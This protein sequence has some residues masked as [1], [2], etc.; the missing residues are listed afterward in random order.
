MFFKNLCIFVLWMKVVLALEGLRQ[1]THNS[2]V[3]ASLIDYN[4]STLAPVSTLLMH[5]LHEMLRLALTLPMLRLL[6][7]KEQGCK[8]FWIPSKPCHVGIHWIALTEYSQMS[9]HVPGFQ[10]FFRFFAT[11][12]IGQTSHQQHIRD[13]LIQYIQSTLTEVCAFHPI[14]TRYT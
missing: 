5:G 1:G 3:A 2:L 13:N 7:S 4:R 9:T 10:S 6:S 12:F 8:Y 11:F 14:R